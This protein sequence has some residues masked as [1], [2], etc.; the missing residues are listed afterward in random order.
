MVDEIIL[1][2]RD[3][4]YNAGLVGLYSLITGSCDENEDTVKRIKDCD[5]GLLVPTELF[6][7]LESRWVD[8]AI[9][10]F[11][12]ECPYTRLMDQYE[13]LGIASEQDALDDAAIKEF[14]KALKDRLEKASYK[15]AYVICRDNGDDFDAITDFKSI[16][17]E[18]G[19]AF[20]EGAKPIIDYLRRNERTFLMK[21]IA[22]TTINLYWTN[23]AFLVRVKNK[24]D[25]ERCIGD[26]FIAPIKSWL[27]DTKKASMTCLQCGRPISGEF[28]ISMTWI[29]DLGVDD[30]RK[31]SNFYNFVPDA[32]VCPVCALVYSCMPFGFTNVGGQGMFI[33]D[34]SSFKRLINTNTQFANPDN[35]INEVEQERAARSRGAFY[36]YR[37]RAYEALCN[38][39]DAEKQLSAVQII[40]RR[41]TGDSAGYVVEQL[42]AGNVKVLANCHESFKR[43]TNCSVKL[44]DGNYLNL[45]SE[46][47]DN[48][49]SGRSQHALMN[50]LIRVY[51]ENSSAMLGISDL[52]RIECYREDNMDFSDKVSRKAF[53]YSDKAAA[54]HDRLSAAEDGTAVEREK[55]VSNKLRGYIYKL[56]N[57]LNARDYRGF[58][59]SVARMHLSVGED[60]PT[61]M[62][63]EMLKDE[64]K[65][66]TYGIA[67]I[68]GLSAGNRRG[69]GSNNGDNKEE[70]KN[71]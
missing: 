4:M 25:I 32:Y 22:Y 56:L 1:E 35:F 70:N 68:Y 24:S 34:C 69:N 41:K 61:D 71:A 30:A 49:M 66:Q 20:I 40:Q 51:L 57:Q 64:D 13:S 45:F 6:E 26:D 52:L 33:N 21:E 29:C 47:A 11:G 12:S 42:S 28:S 9:N 17:D 44:S 15:S 5:R 50:K 8:Y 59:D 63:L 54:M 60:F 62:L 53:Y 46:A 38:K 31:K 39:T 37:Q 27:N 7:G 65:F 23:R 18:A 2:P 16:K 48:L 14:K 3:A 10:K 58:A 19:R 55:K 67:Y 43:L 36:H